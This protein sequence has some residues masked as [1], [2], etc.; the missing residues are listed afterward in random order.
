MVGGGMDKQKYTYTFLI[1]G[2]YNH[3]KFY[4]DSFFLQERSD[5]VHNISRDQMFTCELLEYRVLIKTFPTTNCLTLIL[6]TYNYHRPLY[7]DKRD[8]FYP[9]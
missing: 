2:I 1:V 8:A 5:T 4:T 9:I 6:L 3:C 7:F